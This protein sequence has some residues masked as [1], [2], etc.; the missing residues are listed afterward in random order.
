MAAAWVLTVLAL[1]GVIA[2]GVLGQS[3]TISAHLAAAGGGVLSGICLFWLIPEIA[4]TSGFAFALALTVIAGAALVAL[5]RVLAH[6]GH[7]PRHGMVGPLLLATAIHSFLDGWSVRAL[8]TKPLAGIAVPIG[9]AL[10]KI[11]E[12]LAI[13]WIT[14]KAIGSTARAIL[15]S[16]A[17]E[18]LTVIGA[19]VEP[20][21]ESSG[22]AVFG[23]RWTAAVLTI[24]GGSFLFL[25]FH[26][27]VSERKKV[28]VM[29]VFAMAFGVVGLFA[30]VHGR[31]G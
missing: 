9:L 23:E 10:H 28:G 18:L 27:V 7:S 13:G 19:I 8:A 30:W 31:G 12:G 22:A 14:R 29:P 17:V 26:T 1:I 3:K 16:G 21:A 11:P 15:A 25:G 6:T 2:G 5:D 4:E 24:V 20:P